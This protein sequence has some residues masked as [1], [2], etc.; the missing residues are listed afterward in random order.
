M[1]EPV[2]VDGFDLTLQKFILGRIARQIYFGIFLGWIEEIDVVS[3]VF[4]EAS[5]RWYATT[6]PA[7]RHEDNAVFALYQQFRRRWPPVYRLL[8]RPAGAISARPIRR[9]FGATSSGFR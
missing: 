5:L 8:N 3:P 2:I 6:H 7:D 9:R 1:I 4:H